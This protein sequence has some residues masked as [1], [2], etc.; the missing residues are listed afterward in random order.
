MKQILTAILIMSFAIACNHRN[1]TSEEPAARKFAFDNSAYLNIPHEVEESILRRKLLNLA[2]EERIN[3]AFDKE[4][5]NVAHKVNPEDTFLFQKKT[6]KLDPKSFEE[7][8][9]FSENSAQVVVSYEDRLEIYFV[10]TG[11]SK[12]KALLQLGVQPARDSRFFWL[13]ASEPYLTKNNIYYLLSASN[14][15]LLDNDAFFNSEIKTIGSEFNELYFSFASNQILNLVIKADYL[16]VETVYEILKG[17]KYKCTSDYREAGL[18]S[19]CYFKME[20]ATGAM[21]K[22]VLKN[23]QLVDLDIVVNG[24]SYP[25]RELRPVIDSSGNFNVTLDLKKMVTT[26]LASVEFHLNRPYPVFKNVIGVDY[27]VSC[28]ELGHSKTLDLTPSLK[29]NLEMN[30]LGRNLGMI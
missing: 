28:S 19:T 15:N 14:K 9:R 21:V 2:L 4:K 13:K 25:L 10:P 22:K 7:F 1:T 3:S 29:I 26:D 6:F 17:Q 11:I 23:A 8:G 27:G 12:E 20:A 18:C 24:R 16:E 30:V 5:E